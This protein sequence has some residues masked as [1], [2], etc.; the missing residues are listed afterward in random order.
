MV[1][2]A[3]IITPVPAAL[4]PGQR[5]RPHIGQEAVALMEHKRLPIGDGEEI[6]RVA[7]S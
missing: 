5:W 1:E 7:A 6:Q 2:P 3:T 4:P